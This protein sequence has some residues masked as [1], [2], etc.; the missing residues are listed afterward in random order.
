[1]WAFSFFYAYS[2]VQC[3]E[4]CRRVLDLFVCTKD[5]SFLTQFPVFTTTESTSSGSVSVSLY[6]CDSVVT[7]P[8]GHTINCDSKLWHRVWT[9]NY[10]VY[11]HAVSSW[12]FYCISDCT[13]T[14]AVLTST[15]YSDLNL[16]VK[17]IGATQPNTPIRMF[18]SICDVLQ[19]SHINTK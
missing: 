8:C 5:Q 12:R 15:Q 7:N 18:V 10:P 4:M 2:H 11:F 6:F 13:I 3:A 17:L 19:T 16:M 9:G 14:F 1:M